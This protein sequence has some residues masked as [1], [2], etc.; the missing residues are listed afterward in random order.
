MCSEEPSGAAT[1]LQEFQ[2]KFL[3]TIDFLNDTKE[4]HFSNE[5]HDNNKKIWF[6]NPFLIKEEPYLK[7][8]ST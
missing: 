3:N 8:V 7:K 1:M 6:K 2:E 5:K 4:Q